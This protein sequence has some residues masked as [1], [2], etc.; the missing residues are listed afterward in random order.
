[1]NNKNVTMWTLTLGLL[2]ALSFTVGC[3]KSV[4]S[5]KKPKSVAVS[6]DGKAAYSNNGIKWRMT[7]LPEDDIYWSSVCYG[8]GKFVAVASFIA[9]AYS[10]DGINWFETILPKDTWRSIC[11]GGGKFVAMI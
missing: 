5:G 3:N 1:M 8:D 6:Y 10:E 9:A 11:Y 7:M 2:L 4:D